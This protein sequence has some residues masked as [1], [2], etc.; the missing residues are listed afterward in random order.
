MITLNGNFNV[1][2]TRGYKEVT[3]DDVGEDSYNSL[4]KRAERCAP[5][6]AKPGEESTVV[7]RIRLGEDFVAFNI[8]YQAKKLI[9]PEPLL[10]KSVNEF[11]MKFSFWVKNGDG[12]FV[13]KDIND[14]FFTVDMEKNL[15]ELNADT[16]RS[17]ID[18]SIDR[19]GDNAVRN[20][21]VDSETFI[22]F[23]KYDIVRKKL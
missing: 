9:Q 10:L 6:R 7:V 5:K 4:L 19:L 2:F 17:V 20:L 18:G 16:V 21:G 15:E 22:G 13:Q 3:K 1:T 14:G 11:N 8:K 23:M 12:V